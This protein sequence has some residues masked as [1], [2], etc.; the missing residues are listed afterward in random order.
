MSVGRPV[1]AT[2]TG[3]SGEYLADGGNCLLFPPGDE[4]ALAAALL[5]LAGDGDRRSRLAE[6]A[7]AAVAD[8]TWERAAE[9][10]YAVFAGAVRR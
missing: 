5:S 10:A 6:A 7:E 2:G 9:A 4:A 3:G 1:V 8:L